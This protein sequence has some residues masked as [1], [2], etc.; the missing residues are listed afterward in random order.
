MKGTLHPGEKAIVV[1][2]G[3]FSPQA[4]NEAR[5]TPD[6]FLLDGPEFVRLF[7]DAC[8]RLDTKWQAKFPV[9][10]VYVPES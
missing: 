8:S 6:L 9:K 2:L 5:T 1:S 10:S 3:G 4:L 7:L